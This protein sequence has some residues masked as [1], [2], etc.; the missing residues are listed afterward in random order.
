M[1]NGDRKW[2]T[3]SSAINFPIQ[4]SGGDMKELAVATLCPQYPE[5]EYA[6][7][8]HD[9]LF[10]YVDIDLPDYVLLDMRQTLND[11]PYKEVWG[12]EPPIPLPWDCQVGPHWGAMKELA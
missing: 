9:A 7:D 4:G 1:W 6:F 5:F 3:E 12:F 10:G 11:L 2:G 8:L